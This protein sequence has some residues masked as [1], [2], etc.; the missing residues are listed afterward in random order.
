MVCVSVREI[1]H[2]LKLVDYLPVQTHKPYILTHLAYRVNAKNVIYTVLKAR[3]KRALA[4]VNSN[5]KVTSVMALDGV[6][7]SL[8]LEDVTNIC[9]RMQHRPTIGGISSVQ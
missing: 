3:G 8:R 1:F 2:S 5:C 7:S 6:T 9:K 4:D